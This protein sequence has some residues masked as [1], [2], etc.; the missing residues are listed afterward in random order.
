[1]INDPVQSLVEFVQDIKPFHTKIVEVLV[2]YI[3][4]ESMNVSVT[5]HI[6]WDIGLGLNYHEDGCPHGYGFDGWSVPFEKTLE[7][8]LDI[9][10]FLNQNTGQYVQIGTLVTTPPLPITPHTTDVINITQPNILHVSGDQTS[11]FPIGRTFTISNSFGNDGSWEVTNVIFDNSVTQTRIQVKYVS[12]QQTLVL[13][14]LDSPFIASPGF[15]QNVMSI[16]GHCSDFFGVGQSITVQNSSH[17]HNGDWL[18]T[19]ID[20]NTT[21]SEVTVQHITSTVVNGAIFT[22]V[23]QAPTTPTKLSNTQF[24]IMGVE[25]LSQTQIV[26]PST[27]LVSQYIP[28]PLE[29]SAKFMVSGNQL[30]SFIVNRLVIIEN[31][32]GNDGVWKI[33]STAYNIASGM[34]E[35]VVI[36]DRA[37]VNS[38]PLISGQINVFNSSNFDVPDVCPTVSPTTAL[39]KIKETHTIEISLPTISLEILSATRRTYNG[40]ILVLGK[41]AIEGNRIKNFEPGSTFIVD[42][43]G[44]N[45]GVWTV[46]HSEYNQVLIG[47]ENVWV[48]EIY[49]VEFMPPISFPLGT[50]EQEFAQFSDVVGTSI[51]EST[52]PSAWEYF[53]YSA[54]TS[55]IASFSVY[56]IYLTGDM[57]R[58]FSVGSKITIDTLEAWTHTILTIPT[59]DPLSNITTLS[60]LEPLPQNVSH[61]YVSGQPIWVSGIGWGEGGWSSEPTP[62]L[63]ISLH[64]LD[65]SDDWTVITNYDLLTQP[66]GA[67]GN[68]YFGVGGFGD[69]IQ[70]VLPI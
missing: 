62:W 3:H 22:N 11:Y 9:G 21:F 48:T 70:Q 30:A 31:S 54:P 39:T 57:R 56:W 25:E 26:N 52:S 66:Q 65:G 18:V 59:Y 41:F 16:S 63:T 12:N 61:Q 15:Y 37:Y 5:E 43:S 50:I 33:V 20:D 10:S 55:P 44:S 17:H 4:Q 46:D 40:P 64:P 51:V 69:I 32:S 36:F 47:S 23:S 7:N 19:G 27:G 45:D 1:M 53:Y 13:F 14:E 28:N 34:T 38:V 35:I 49:V 8:T 2:D 68:Y 29:P 6:D 42:N 67:F 24:N 60:L 58:F